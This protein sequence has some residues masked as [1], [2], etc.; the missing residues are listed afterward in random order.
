MFVTRLIEYDLEPSGP[1]CATFRGFVGNVHCR[2]G[3]VAF[4]RMSWEDG[5]RR[6]FEPA[7]N[8]HARGAPSCGSHQLREEYPSSPDTKPRTSPGRAPA[9]T[10]PH[11][12]PSTRRTP[13]MREDARGAGQ[14]HNA[15]SEAVRRISPMPH[16]FGGAAITG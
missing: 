12:L 8:T 3:R 6:A 16:R 11:H 5:M 14:G 9:R 10:E 13:L 4:T 15:Q 1:K 7:G 2:L